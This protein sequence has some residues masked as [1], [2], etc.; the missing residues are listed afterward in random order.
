M[1]GTPWESKYV[2][3]PFYK[4]ETNDK[5]MCEE[6]DCV[7][8]GTHII[9]PTSENKREYERKYCCSLRDHKDC[10]IASALYEAYENDI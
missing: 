6:L 4:R 8:I 2:Q 3:C 7:S 9:F 10:K 5:I 1:K